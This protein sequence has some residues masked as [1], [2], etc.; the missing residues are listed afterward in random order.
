QQWTTGP[1]LNPRPQQQGFFGQ[2]QAT[3]V[4]PEQVLQQQIAPFAADRD[5]LTVKILTEKPEK[6]HDKL[7]AM[8]IAGQLPDVFAYDGPQAMPLV[9]SGQLYHLGRLQG[10]SSRSFLQSF[11]SSYLDASSYRG[12]LYGLPY[13]SRQLVLYV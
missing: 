3:P 5:D 12:K 7:N 13:Q 6:Y 8:A 11:P 4:P 1:G 9:K 10:A 2:G